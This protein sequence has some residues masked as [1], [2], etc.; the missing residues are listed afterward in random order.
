MWRAPASRRWRRR[1]AAPNRCIPT[2]SMRRWRCRR[3]SPP[4]SR[5]TPRSC[6]SARAAPPASIDPWGGS[7]YVERLTHDLARKPGR[8]SSEV[9]EMGGMAKAI[10]A[11]LPKLRIEESAA[12]TQARIDSGPQAVIGVNK[13]RPRDEAPIEILKVDNARGAAVADRQARPPQARARSAGRR[14]GAGRAHAQRRRRQRQSARACDRCRARQGDG[15]RNFVGAGARSLAAIKP[16]SS[17]SPAFTGGRS[18]C[19]TPSSGCRSSS[20]NSRRT[21]AAGRASWSPRSARTATTAA[22]R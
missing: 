10:E 13:Y 9:E 2:R 7:F 5:A 11:A 4:A 18:A 14:R 3:T 19:R 15:R 12:R 6:F 16:R 17:R 20:P 21:K 1:K 8:I 22:R